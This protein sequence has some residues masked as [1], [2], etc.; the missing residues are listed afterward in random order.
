[1]KYTYLENMGLEE[2]IRAYKSVLDE[3]GISVG[4]EEIPVQESLGRITS[5]AVFARISSPH[6]NACAMDG[7]AVLARS[8]FGATETTPVLLKEGEDF[9][10]VDTGDPLP[11]K[12]DAVVMVEEVIVAGE[13]GEKPGNCMDESKGRLIVKLIKPAVPWQNVRQIGEDLCAFDMII[14]S[15][16]R[17]GPAEIG[18]MLAG[19]VLAVKVWKRP[20]VGLVPTG[21]EVVSPTDCPRKGEIIEF[22][23]SIFSAMLSGWGAKSKIYG[24]VPDKLDLIRSAVEKAAEECDMVILNAGSSAGREDYS[25]SA[26][27][28]AGKVILH[29]IAIR[30]GKPTILGIVKGRPVIGV[31]GYPVS[32]II[33]MEKVVKPVLDKIAHWECRPVKSVKA[34]LTRKIVSSLKYE[35]FVRMKLGYVDGR[36]TATPLNRGAGVVTSFTRAD[37]LMRIPV[38]SEGFEAGRLVD[39]EL[40]R[41]EAAVRN[42]LSVIG[43]HDMLIDV[44]GDH[45][46]KRFPGEYVSSAHV[47]SMG[48]IMAIKRG[49]AHIAG[50]HLLDEQTGE[51]NESYVRKYLGGERIL[52]VKCVK[53]IQGLM[54]AKGNPQNISGL[55]DLTRKGIRYV[56]RQRGSGTRILLDYLLKTKGLDAGAIYGYER[57][58]FTHMSV[59]ALIASGIADAGLGIYAAARIY[60]LDF[61]PV[62]EEQYDFILPERFAEL[63]MV[64]HFIETLKSKEFKEELE[65]MS[66]YKTDNTGSIQCIC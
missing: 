55:Q 40:L 39:I 60:N 1:M 4:A 52:L 64:Q 57:E 58:E 7:I 42:T 22:N 11:D 3:A 50:I 36:L 29:G 46:R 66:G 30:P 59:A 63:D 62:W 32:G 25:A 18:A 33:V 31:P 20:V 14:P 21:D 6:Y 38:N 47:G 10:W 45:F 13:D 8:T 5:E 23:S 15:N 54:V 48:G 49:E 56:N 9:E 26:I 41:D 44:I 17:I 27:K 51:Y 19:G 16:T 28:E 53:R 37:G 43:S 2:A 61:I 35:E 24:I 34:V 12:Y 65:R